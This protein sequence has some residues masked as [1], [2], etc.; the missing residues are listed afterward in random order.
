MIKFWDFKKAD[1][2][3][4]ELYLY[5]TIS[6]TS[7]YGDEI[8]PKQFKADL[9]A[10]GEIDT[11]KVFVNSGGGDVFAGWNIINIL[12]RHT[13]NKIGY[14]DGLAGSIAF[15]I[16]MA[17]DKVIAMENSM[18][19]SHNCWAFIIGNRHELRKA[20]DMMEKIDKMLVET[21]AKRSG[22][23]EEEMMA[24]QDA[25][26]WYTAREALDEGFAD[27]LEQGKQIAAMV[28][29]EMLAKY[30]H[31]PKDL[32]HEEP[33][34]G[35]FLLPEDQGQEPIDRSES[36]PVKDISAEL[37]AQRDR[38][39]RTKIKQYGGSK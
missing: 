14:N 20:A 5:G 36:E 34:D 31:P 28:T 27:E 3:T 10:L 23:T 4:G 1:E 13:A 32:I 19:M 11:L 30:K 18:F 33:P 6:S 7:W 26:T 29:P 16:L 15:D 9:D 17:M 12:A 25:E 8:T 37:A 35:G 24:I 22:K 2:K 39:T 21:A 38:F